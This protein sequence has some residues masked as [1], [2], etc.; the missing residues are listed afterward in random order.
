M[1]KK[2]KK[3]EPLDELPTKKDEHFKFC[4]DCDGS[5]INPTDETKHCQTC[6]GSGM[7]KA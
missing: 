1:S 4:P 5:G 2:S 7:I 3:P 6:Q